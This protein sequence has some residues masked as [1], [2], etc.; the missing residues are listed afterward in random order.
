MPGHAQTAPTLLYGLL[1]IVLVLFLTKGRIQPACAE[2]FTT[3]SPSDDY[4]YVGN[5]MAR[6]DR[7]TNYAELGT[8]KRFGLRTALE[9]CDDNKECGYVH[10]H[11]EGNTWRSAQY[12]DGDSENVGKAKRHRLFRKVETG[13]DVGPDLDIHP[14]LVDLGTVFQHVFSNPVEFSAEYYNLG[15]LMS[16]FMQLFDDTYPTG[17]TGQGEG[18]WIYYQAAKALYDRLKQS[19]KSDEYTAQMFKDDIT[20]TIT[21]TSSE[22]LAHGRNG[23]MSATVVMPIVGVD[24]IPTFMMR[25][26]SEFSKSLLEGEASGLPIPITLVDGIITHHK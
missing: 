23:P 11:K 22:Y 12:R 20:H 19:P 3:N 25:I 1:F 15:E 13:D 7:L 4:K 6:S 16:A 2:G 10:L 26:F 24:W 9:Q 21:I 8:N 5:K 14:V 17:I 18:D